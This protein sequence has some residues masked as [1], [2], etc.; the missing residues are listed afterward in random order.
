[1]APAP[2][3]PTASTRSQPL[4]SMHSP[5]IPL[6]RSDTRQGVSRDLAVRD[7][8]VAGGIAPLTQDP[9]PE[10]LVL[11][12]TDGAGSALALAVFRGEQPMSRPR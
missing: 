10:D 3:V 7:T 4:S 1:M 9:P 8:L 5:D 2:S 6:R 12:T 11:A